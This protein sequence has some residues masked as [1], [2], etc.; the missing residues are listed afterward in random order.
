LSDWEL[1]LTARKAKE[2]HSGRVDMARQQTIERR[3]SDYIQT[4]FSFVT[5]PADEKE[6]RLRLEARLISTISLCETC[7]PSTAWL[8]RFSPKEKIGKSGLW[9]VNELYGQPLSNEELSELK[10]LKSRGA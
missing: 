9:L 2:Q 6:Q 4:S 8:G 10:D 3:V 5:V 1:D 7:R